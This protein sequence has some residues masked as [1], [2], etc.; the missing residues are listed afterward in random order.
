P[1]AVRQL[2]KAGAR[3]AAK[4]ARGTT[5]ADLGRFKAK[6]ANPADRQKFE[7]IIQLLEPPE[8]EPVYSNDFSM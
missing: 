1:E 6:Q 4:D 2:L 5:P 3:P 8:P 7:Q